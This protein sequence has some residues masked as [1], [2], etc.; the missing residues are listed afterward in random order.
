MAMIALNT[1]NNLERL[2]LALNNK[3]YY[4]DDEYRLFLE[5]SGLYPEDVYIKDTMEIQLLETVI[6]VLESLSNDVDMMR[7]VSSD[8]IGLTTDEAYKYLATRIKTLNEKILTLK[9]MNESQEEYSN[10]R[11]I[12]FNNTITR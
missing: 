10:I 6:V 4:T 5:E 2:K 1:K 11:P 7:R 12:F 9:E 3:E 8:E